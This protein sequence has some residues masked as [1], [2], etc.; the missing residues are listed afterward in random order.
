MDRSPGSGQAIVREARRVSNT[1]VY[2]SCAEERVIERFRLDPSSGSLAR[3]GRTPIPGVDAPSATSPLAISPDRRFLYAALREE[4]NPVSSFAI[5]GPDGALQHLATAPLPE[6]MCYIETDPEGRWLLSASYFGAVVAVSPI[7]PD[8]AVRR[9][10]TQ[11]VKTPPKAHCVLFEPDGKHVYAPCLGGDAVLLW[12]WD[13]EAGLVAPDAFRQASLAPGAGPRHLTF[14]RDGR[15]AYVV[16]ELDG[17]VTVFARAAESGE[18]TPR[19]TIPAAAGSVPG[20]AAAADI[21]LSPDGRFLYASVRSDS[22]L[23]VFAV[24]G[25][26]TLNPIERVPVETTPRGFAIDPSGRVLVCAG[27]DAA[28]CGTYAIDP[29]SGRLSRREHVA[30]GGNPNWVEI[31]ELDAAAS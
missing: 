1:I 27:R 6:S 31:I 13:A 3:L 21:H 7:D 19:Q 16:N 8:G 30:V 2:V 18:L 10:P 23:A 29:S 28:A 5:A 4:P 22:H 11:I 25:D 12:H 24:N 15:A 26:A 9:A 20:S 14:S 17:T